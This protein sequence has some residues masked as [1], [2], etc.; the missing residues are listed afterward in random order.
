MDEIIKCYR[1]GKRPKMQTVHSHFFRVKCDCGVVQ[2]ALFTIYDNAVRDWNSF[3]HNYV[4]K[5][6]PLIDVI[7]D[8]CESDFSKLIQNVSVEKIKKEN[9][10]RCLMDE[11]PMDKP[12]SVEEVCKY[13][14]IGTNQFYKA[15]KK[16]KSFK[17]YGRIFVLKKNAIEWRQKNPP[18]EKKNVEVLK[19]ILKY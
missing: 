11:W 18:R 9:E 3:Q 5:L 8:K 6:P 10:K 1:C 2:K 16:M 17:K 14:K 4:S 15:H 12:L 13:I 19:N 7:K